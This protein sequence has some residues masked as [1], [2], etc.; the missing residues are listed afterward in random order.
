MRKVVGKSHQIL[1]KLPSHRPITVTR[2]HDLTLRLSSRGGSVIAAETP[3]A[4]WEIA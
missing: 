2:K 1:G 4:A 3:V